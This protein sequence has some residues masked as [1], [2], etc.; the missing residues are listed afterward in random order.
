MIDGGP[1][2]QG[3]PPIKHVCTL[4][5]GSYSLGPSECGRCRVER[6]PADGIEAY[7]LL[8]QEAH[9]RMAAPRLQLSPLRAGRAHK[10]PPAGRPIEALSVD[11]LIEWLEMERR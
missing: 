9:A 3:P 10:A 7:A 11:E 1:Y 6:V 2:R 5:F 4:C 8:L